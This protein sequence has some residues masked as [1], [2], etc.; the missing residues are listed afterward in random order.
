MFVR[1]LHMYKLIY[2]SYYSS[3]STDEAWAET[4][5]FDVE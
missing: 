2:F 3:L 5:G 1:W 4:M